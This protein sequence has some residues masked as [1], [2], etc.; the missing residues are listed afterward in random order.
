[1]YPKRNSLVLFWK[2]WNERAKKSQYYEEISKK[3]ADLC[4]VDGIELG[5]A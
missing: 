3:I 2:H 1:M 5:A 4:G